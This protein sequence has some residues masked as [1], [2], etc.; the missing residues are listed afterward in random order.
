MLMTSQAF[1]YVW[2]YWTHLR[3]ALRYT[4]QTYN[5][6]NEADTAFSGQSAT[7]DRTNGMTNAA[8]G[9]GTTAQSGS[10]PGLLNPESV[11]PLPPTP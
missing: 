5:T 6:V 9:M 10:N 8:V 7:F 1:S 4:D 3:D 2:S 11:K